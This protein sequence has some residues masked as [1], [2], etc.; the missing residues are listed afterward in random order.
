MPVVGLAMATLSTYTLP[1][2]L[3]EAERLYRTGEFAP[4]LPRDS[5]VM[6]PFAIHFPAVLFAALACGSLQVGFPAGALL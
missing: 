6:R 4:V 3:G 1:V 2:A 5:H